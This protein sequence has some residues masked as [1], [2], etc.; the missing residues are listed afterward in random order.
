MTPAETVALL[1]AIKDNAERL[2]LVWQIRTGTVQSSDAAL[3]VVTFDNDEAP[4]VGITNMTG[5]V[6]ALGE[7]VY[8]VSVPPA[9][10]YVVGYMNAVRLGCNCETAGSMSTGTTSST[11]Y[12]AQP[13]SPSVQ[14]TK[15]FD[16]T[17][18]KF[19]WA[20][21]YYTTSATDAEF[22]AVSGSTQ[23]FLGKHHTS[24]GALNSHTPISGMIRVAGI[25]AGRRTWV[26]SWST[27]TGGG[28]L[29]VDS[30]DFWTMCIEEFWRSE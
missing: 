7:R 4:T 10:Q 26:G 16:D 22:A 15:K 11:V 5:T 17:Q 6:L 8:V 13:G 19:S 30:G 9:G 21:T 23:V 29:K 25:P 28:T 18:L 12:V 3:A 20:Q 1:Q 27:P 24:N 14:L 2:G